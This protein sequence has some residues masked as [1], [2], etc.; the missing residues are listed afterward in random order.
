MDDKY[1]TWCQSPKSLNV[2]SCYF[3]VSVDD[4]VTEAYQGCS[5][6]PPGDPR[7]CP[8]TFVLAQRGW[9]TLPWEAQSS[10]PAVISFLVLFQALLKS[11]VASLVVAGTCLCQAWQVGWCHCSSISKGQ[12]WKRP[13][14]IT[15]RFLPSC[16]T[17]QIQREQG[18]RGSLQSWQLQVWVYKWFEVLDTNRLYPVC[19]LFL[20]W[21]LILVSCRGDRFQRH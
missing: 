5:L 8:K 13:R 20:L 3:M 21:P 10:C 1:W 12:L 16:L 19:C 15:I 18:A 11:R 14:G 17:W 9:V 7:W 4:Y 6:F 2:Y